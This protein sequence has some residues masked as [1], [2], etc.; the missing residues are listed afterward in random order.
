MPTPEEE[1]EGFRNN[2]PVK[3]M[4]GFHAEAAEIMNKLAD[5]GRT[6][7]AYNGPA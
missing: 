4:Y 5:E 2:L 3:M 7:A 6:K 1:Y